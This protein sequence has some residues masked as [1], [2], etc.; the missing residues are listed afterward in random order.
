M[1]ERAMYWLRQ[2]AWAAICVSAALLVLFG[3]AR[4]MYIGL[5]VAADW[6]R[7]FCIVQDGCPGH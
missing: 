6:L 7:A 1:K 2:A 3:L 4:L 5:P